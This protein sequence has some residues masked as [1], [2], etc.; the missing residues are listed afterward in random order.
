MP[1][2]DFNIILDRIKKPLEFASRD[3]FANL[4]R[5]AA[6][7]TVIRAQLEELRRFSSEHIELDS[8]E[9]LFLGFDNLP[10]DQKKNHIMKATALIKVLEHCRGEMPCSAH[11]ASHQSETSSMSYEMQP[12][13]RMDTP[14][15]FCKGI[16]PKLAGLLKKLG[17]FTVED[18]LFHL[19][20]RYEDRGNL[21]KIGRLT[22]GSYETVMGEVVSAEVTRTRRRWVQI[23]EL[24]IKDTSGI[25]V[26][27]WY[28][29]PFRHKSF[30]T[31]QTVILSGIVKSNPYRGGI[32]QIDNPEYEIMD[33]SEPDSLI[34]TCRIVPIYRT[35]AGLTVRTLRSRM[36]AIIDSCCT[37]ALGSLPDYLM[38]KYSLM[39]AAEAF[40][41]VHFP[42]R[43]K[44]VVILNG[45]KSQAHR[46][47]SFEELFIL[48]L[49]L[50]LRKKNVATE[51]KGISFN[52]IG[53]L[54]KAFRK[55]LPYRLTDSQ[56]RV[57]AEIKRDMTAARP[58]NRLVQGDVGCG[59][60]VVAM[61]VT[62][63]AV[64][65]GHQVCIM[66]PT[67]ILAEQHF[68]NIS[69]M[70]GPLG[71]TVRSLTGRMKNKEK[72][73]VL[74]EIGSG[75]AQIIIGT[76][77]LIE[78]N[79][80]FKRLGLAVIDEQHRFGVMQRSML[81]SKGYEPD[82]L[83]MTATPIPRTLALTVYGDLDISVIDEMPPGRSPVLTKLYV[84]ARRKEA[85][86][87]IEDELKKGRQVYVVY[88]LV[89][90]TEKSD[91]K[92]ATEMAAN[93]QMKIFPNRRVGLLHGRMKPHEKEAVM[94]SFK[95]GETDILVSTTVIEVGVDVPN[96]TVMMIEHPERFG[97][98]QLHQL[99]GR[100]GR[101][102]HQ[103]YCIL[104][105]P[106]MFAEEA[107]ERLNA[108]VRTSDGFKLA[109]EDLRLRGPGEFFGTRQSGLPDLRAANIIRDADLLE[110]ART[111][112]FE[113]VMKDPSLSGY[114]YLRETLRRKWMGK[115]GL[116]I[117]G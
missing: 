114:P 9:R 53:K 59:K 69:A 87:F 86:Q 17:I 103:S 63:I 1:T 40:S 12:S 78:E 113:L 21:K 34:H 24:V 54:E 111:E 91:L 89:E 33:E 6:L 18:A 49:G 47:L 50:A 81:T 109:E 13:L 90:E 35:T 20:W 29:Q 95:S 39:S 3:N 23:F 84:E 15:Q 77:A 61:V 2:D 52:A 37:T 75:A 100:V 66:A 73:S 108:I 88:P 85:Y 48:Q 116:I 57:I 107:R 42:V 43:E 80:K 51:K 5:V 31:G 117:V 38:R 67:E 11:A 112:A 115:L 4:T 19:P 14:V 74:E 65:N 71:I 98:A 22:Y 32:P 64:E 56:E 41:E 110:M 97:L 94:L 28:N 99:R 10:I 25:L 92:A 105:G 16:G 7:E 44:N 83:V 30:K 72:E 76:H 8:I 58:M 55:M 45:G 82:V 79:V 101:G 46:R 96:A 62:L 104:I 60:T 27:S 93:L 70:A 106:R 26:G 102:M 68:K 36:K